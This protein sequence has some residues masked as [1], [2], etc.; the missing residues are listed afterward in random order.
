M[1]HLTG[2]DWSAGLFGL[3]LGIIIGATLVALM[4]ERKKLQADAQDILVDVEQFL[5][6]P[7]DEPYG[8]VPAVPVEARREP[9]GN[10]LLTRMYERWLAAFHSSDPVS[11]RRQEIRM[12]N[13]GITP[14][15]D[16]AQAE[17]ELAILKGD[18][19]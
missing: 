12:L 14:P 1:Q 11:Q 6:D 10:L 18:T 3:A 4:R 2:L 8:D 19:P 16:F 9:H 7:G 17:R 5:R 15:A 13:A